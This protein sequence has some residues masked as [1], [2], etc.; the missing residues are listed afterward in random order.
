MG[1]ANLKEV[2]PGSNFLNSNSL[3]HNSNKFRRIDGFESNNQIPILLQKQIGHR[4]TPTTK[5][6][7][8]LNNLQCISKDNYA[9]F[10]SNSFGSISTDGILNNNAF[11][12]NPAM[13]RAL[14]LDTMNCNACFTHLKEC[15]D[16]REQA[17]VLLSDSNTSNTTSNTPKIEAFSNNKTE[18]MLELILFIGAGAL[19]LF[20]LK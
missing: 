20:I 4:Y 11:Q 5:F 3:S 9:P 14:E 7:G 10:K 2:F 8:D 18:E 17:L 19:L 6:R 15:S 16:C 13:E 1:Y 12:I